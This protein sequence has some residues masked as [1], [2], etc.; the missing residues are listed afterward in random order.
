MLTQNKHKR[1]HIGVV[2]NAFNPS[3]GTGWW[4]SQ[5]KASLV[6][7]VSSRVLGQPG[8]YRD[9]LSQKKKKKKKKKKIKKNKKPQK[10]CP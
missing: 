3:T 2:V 6:Y 1:P 4:I 10:N 7:G 5:F 8:L 9:T